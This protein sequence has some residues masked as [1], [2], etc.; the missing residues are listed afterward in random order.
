MVFGPYEI[1]Y[2]RCLFVWFS[3]IFW[4]FLQSDI[5]FNPFLSINKVLIIM[6]SDI[7]NIIYYFNEKE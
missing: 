7:L 5:P 3:D 2:W 4:Y 1:Q 6:Q